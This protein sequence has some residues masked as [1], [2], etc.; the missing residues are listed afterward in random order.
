[1]KRRYYVSSRNEYERG[2]WYI[3]DWEKKGVDAT[4]RHVAEVYSRRFGRRIAKLL[5]KDDIMNKT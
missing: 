3:M 1:M 4:N 2:C 5:N